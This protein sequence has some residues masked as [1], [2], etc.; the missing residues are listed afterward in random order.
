M[1]VP[2]PMIEG[3]LRNMP[4]TDV[5]QVIATAHK[6]GTLAL[7]RGRSRA[8]VYFAEGRV[9]Y[10][11]VSP[12][13]NLAETLVRMDLL[14]IEHALTLLTRQPREN[15]GLP[16]GVA[17][18][19]AGYLGESELAT[20][21]GRHVFEVLSELLLWRSGTFSFGEGDD[22]LPPL[23]FEGFDAMM[24]FMKVAQQLSEFEEGAA[25]PTDI[26]RQAGDPTKV[27]M[28]ANGWEVLAAVDGRRHAAAV[29]AE[30]DLPERQ[31]YRLL[32]SLERL[33]VVERSPFP[34]ELP[35]VLLL[36]S[37]NAQGRLLRLLLARCRAVA[38]IEMDPAK[39]LAF[40]ADHHLR[41]VVVDDVDGSGWQFVRDLRRL[42]GKSHLPAVVLT[43]GNEQGVLARVRRPR[44]L[45]LRKPFDE[46]SFQQLLTKMV[47]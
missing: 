40:V 20:A 10:A 6:S 18:M 19:E 3:S 27:E 33:G 42:P 45:T 41:A 38:H 21:L 4:L 34:V 46:L 30:V 12:G 15:P 26:Y 29:A 36:T 23:P 5:F 32:Q 44:A 7:E 28:P 16:L 37:S 22:Q 31:S 11:S 8:R 43:T 17:A 2:S 1:T 39:G 35:Q 47:G 14:T 13:V 24:L 25:S 9:R